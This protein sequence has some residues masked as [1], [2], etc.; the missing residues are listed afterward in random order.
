LFGSSSGH[1]FSLHLD[2][3]G[4]ASHDLSGLGVWCG[5]ITTQLGTPRGRYDEHS[6]KSY[7]DKKP[8]LI[9]PE[10]ESQT[11]EGDAC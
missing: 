8:R 10:G 4:M 1:G 3:L 7:L 11:S 5:Q 9:E 2:H 6:S